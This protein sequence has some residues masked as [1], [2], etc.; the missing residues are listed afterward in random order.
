MGGS[1][2]VEI[3][4]LRQFLAVAE[5]LH[6]SRAADRLHLAQPA[7]SANIRK[8]ENSL[9]L[10]LFKRST[11]MVEL[12]NEGQAFSAHA[13]VA[14]EGYDRALA[15]AAHLRGR[16]SGP[17][18]LGVYAATGTE[19][20]RAIVN[21]LREVH[22]EIEL[23]IVAESSVKLV[24]AVLERRIDAALCVAPTGATELRR[25][26]ITNEPMSVALP[27]SHPLANRD[28]VSLIELASDEWILPSNRAF[29][30]SSALHRLCAR[31]GFT[32]RV[33]DEVSDFDDRFT[34]VAEGQGIEV[35]PQSFVSH[36]VR[37]DVV[38]LPIDQAVLPIY[39]V[40]RSDE[41]SPTLAAVFEAVVDATEDTLVH[42]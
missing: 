38:V 19:V 4:H 27:A 24:D 23:T 34:S 16:G 8:L 2:N 7:L 31:A 42:S 41:A 12:T 25:L 17:V 18:T 20:K 6:F 37:D 10:R 21:R 36:P 15:A 9:Q 35:V 39:L 1:M 11:R 14:V 29:R 3:R 30:E 13:R 5:E 32:M 22:P 40:C 33:A 28:S 26:L